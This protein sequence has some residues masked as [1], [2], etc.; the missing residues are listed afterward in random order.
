MFRKGT[1][2]NGFDYFY[3][4]I[5]ET[6]R[7]ILRKI[8]VEDAPFYFEL[9]NDPDWIKFINDKGLNS[10]KETALYLQNEFI[11]NICV[12]GLGFFTVFKKENNTPIGASSVLKR[13]KLDFVDIGYGFLP[14]GRGKGYA[15]EA[16]KRIIQY[17]KN[18][19]QQPKIFAFTKP[20]NEKS[21]KLLY[22]LSFQHK[23]L[24]RVFNNEN[25]SVFELKLYPNPLKKS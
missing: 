17:A 3:K 21:Q 14:I 2:L 19:L 22:S 6:E 15:K 16:T 20:N 25:S 13:E 23:G 24:K 18:E 9:F 10:V 1:T 12:N 5:L 8:K 11:P 4:M 7:L